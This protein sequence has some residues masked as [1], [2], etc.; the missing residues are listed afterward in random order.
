MADIR[1][2][3]APD[4][5]DAQVVVSAA[6]LFPDAVVIVLATTIWD[7][8]IAAGTFDPKKSALRLEDDVGTEY[9]RVWG[10]GLADDWSSSHAVH[11]MNPEFEPPLPPEATSLRI[12]LGRWGSV[13][14]TI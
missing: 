7:E 5:G 12:T 4:Q 14:L 10:L 3:S 11:R 2:I 8:V 13:A 1:F 9:R 6:E